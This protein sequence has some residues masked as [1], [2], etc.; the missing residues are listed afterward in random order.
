MA[1]DKIVPQ[2]GLQSKILETE[3]N[4]GAWTKDDFKTLV[5]LHIDGK[6]TNQI[7]EALGRSAQAVATKGSRIGLY[8][9]SRNELQQPDVAVRDC[10]NPV[11]PHPF[12][13]TGKGNRTCS[14]CKSKQVH[15]A[16]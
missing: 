15:Q 16:T 4:E 14:V 9:L 6:P 3:M 2:T 5:Q 12:V 10:L 13:S 8:A 7:A 11:A 1:A